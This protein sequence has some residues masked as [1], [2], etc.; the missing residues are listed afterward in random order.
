MSAVTQVIPNMLGGVSQQP[1]P[2]KLPGQVREAINAYLDPTFGCRKRP[3]TKFIAELD[4]DIPLSAKWLSI[5][6]DQSERYVVA[7][8][9]DTGA[10]VVRVWEA[11]TGVE[12]YVTINAAADAYFSGANTEDISHVTIGDYTLIANGNRVVSM[13]GGT[14]VPAELAFVTID[15]LGYNTTYSIYLDKD[16]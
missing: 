13:G 3:A 2:I 5:F 8:Y 14:P 15:Q 9:H 6:R 4:T 12:R 16:G 1:D 10:F 11:A 7:C